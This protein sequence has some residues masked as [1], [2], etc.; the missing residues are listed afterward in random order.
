MTLTI[1]DK[2]RGPRLKVWTLAGLGRYSNNLKWSTCE[3]EGGKKQDFVAGH[4]S[5]GDA[6]QTLSSS[7]PPQPCR[8]TKTI[9]ISEVSIVAVSSQ[10]AKHVSIRP[11]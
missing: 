6:Q 4:T 10:D 9:S 2:C 8:Y 1:N 3:N 5:H 7:G 11:L